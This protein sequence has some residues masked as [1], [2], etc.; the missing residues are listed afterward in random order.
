M[1]GIRGSSII[2]GAIRHKKVVYAITLLLIAVGIT[3]LVRMNRDEFPTFEITQGLVAA[4]YPGA[5]AAQVRDEVSIPLEKALMGIQ[6]VK[7]E[8]LKTVTREG[9]CYIYLDVNTPVEKK[10]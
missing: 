6:E 5:T 10:D 4:V 8:T 9:I 1:S 7:R 3:G 2:L